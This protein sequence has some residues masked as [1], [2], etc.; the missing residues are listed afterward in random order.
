[1]DK[2]L[3][4]KAPFSLSSSCIMWL[5]HAEHLASLR[6][7]NYFTFAQQNQVFSITFTPTYVC[8]NI[9]YVLKN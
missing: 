2:W 1:M 5:N 3:Q 6:S 9:M 4:T 8:F 7:W